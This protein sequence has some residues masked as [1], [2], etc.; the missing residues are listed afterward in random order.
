MNKADSKLIEDLNGEDE[1]GRVLRGHIHLEN[2]ID[3]FLALCCTQDSHLK[4]AELEYHQ[5]LKMALALGLPEWLAS[6]LKYVGTL[7][8]EFAHNLDRHLGEQEMENFYKSFPPEEKN[9]IQQTVART[10][11]NF[12]DKHVTLRSMPPAD[13]FNILIISLEGALHVINKNKRE[14]G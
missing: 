10:S 8:N 13:R 1:L 6:P 4:G 11:R 3:E 7:R 14:Q 5:K 12:P 9:F 2:G